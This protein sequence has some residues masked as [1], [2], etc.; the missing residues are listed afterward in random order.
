[1][2]KLR[3]LKLVFRTLT[4]YRWTS[5][6]VVLSAMVGSA[7]L[8]GSLAVGDSVDYSLKR[9]VEARLGDTE[10]AMH[11]GDR[12]FREK[13]ADELAEGLNAHGAAMLFLDGMAADSDE[14]LLVNEVNILGVDEFFF[15]MGDAARG[16]ELE[17]RQVALNSPLAERLR[18]EAGDEVILRVSKP[19]M[20]PRNVAL[21]PGAELSM[22]FRLKVAKVLEAADFGWFALE[23]NQKAT[24]NAFLC[25]EWLAEELGRDGQSN[26]ILVGGKDSELGAEEANVQMGA[27]WQLCD[28]ELELRET[29]DDRLELRSSRV[30]IDHVLGDAAMETGKNK[31]SGIL[32]YFVNSICAGEQCTPYSTVAAMTPG[33]DQ[34]SIIDPDMGDDEIIINHWLAEDLGVELGDELELIYYVVG[35]DRQLTEDSQ[36]FEVREVVPI[37]GPAADPELMPDFPG[38]AG[39]D[40]C[41]DWDPGIPVELERIRE[42]DERYWEEYRGTPKAFVTL[43]AGQEMWANQ[44]GEL[45]AV[46][47]GPEMDRETVVHGLF[48]RVSPADLGLVFRDVREGA[49]AAR[50]EA[51]GFGQLFIGFNMFLIAAALILVGLVFVFAVESRTDQIGM[52]KA[53]GCTDGTVKKLLAVE[54]CLLALGGI[55]FGVLAGL[56]YTSIMIRWL[57]RVF[58]QAGEHMII[59]FDFE[60]ITVMAGGAGIFIMSMAVIWW[61]VQKKMKRPARELLSGEGGWHF[62]TKK[63]KSNRTGLF[64]ALFCLATAVAL[65]LTFGRAAAG[66]EQAGVFFGVGS[67]LLIGGLGL[68]HYGLNRM[69]GAFINPMTHLRGFGLR[70]ATRSSGRT[71]AVIALLSAGVFVVIAVGANRQDALAD[72]DR[73][74]SGTGGFALF[75]R[76]AISVPYGL[77]TLEGRE[78]AGLDLDG[79]EDVKIVPMRVRRGDDASCFNLNRPQQPRLLGVDPSLFSG[80]FGFLEVIGDFETA[81]GWGLL[82]ENFGED[83]VPAVGDAPTVRWALGKSV[84]DKIEYTDRRG[85]AFKV[86]IVGIINDSVLQGGLVISEKDFRERFG[87]EGY[88]LFLV[89]SQ[90][91]DTENLRILFGEDLREFGLEIMSSKERLAEFAAVEN[92]YISMF[93]I[94]GGLGL[95]L[96][97][98]G[99]GVV[100]LRNVLDRRSELAML[101][102]M[103]YKK[104]VL[105]KMV[106]YEHA[107][108]VLAGLALG[109]VV[110]LVAVSPQILAPGMEV[111]FLSL[112]VIVAAIAVSGFVW[113]WLAVSISLAGDYFDF[114]RHE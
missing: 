75:G 5:I 78:S 80:R 28:A 35:V 20:M 100:V 76:S 61:S 39:V 55:A 21:T 10:L 67:L 32:T 9:M 14:R 42:K 48:D 99:L 64:I 54:G 45:T 2:D 60:W 102:A 41:R 51:M 34:Y 65:L 71:L 110:A 85:R 17:G 23:A 24:Y 56:G 22:A 43:E 93:Q 105:K 62:H 63:R 31:R 101:Q 46:R 66:A 50:D 89:D 81:R 25:R 3:L 88:G 104:A 112:A 12:F 19:T 113:I 33:E 86:Q 70:N 92:T 68:F 97:S 107:G 90:E 37:E 36:S 103:G 98:I 83:V 77:A 106:F 29:S 96:G 7:I 49:L 13:I 8:I 91:G 6:G 47:Y 53:I 114:L 108:M 87:F 38:L 26:I 1:M 111:P 69:T 30:F 11:G 73:M 4:F 109:V 95:V 82:E 72:A 44:Y 52:F 58:G 79:L 27:L 18:V 57:S 59:A 15:E 74:D 16:I 94:L 84:G 40:D